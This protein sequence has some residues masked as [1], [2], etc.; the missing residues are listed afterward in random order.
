VSFLASI[1]E[2]ENLEEKNEDFW[3]LLFSG[4]QKGISDSDQKART[5]CYNSI[6]VLQAEVIH[7]KNKFHFLF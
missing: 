5:E 4:L 7:K 6:K 3:Q 1:L 2:K